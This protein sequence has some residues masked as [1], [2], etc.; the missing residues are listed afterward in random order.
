M[1]KETEERGVWGKHHAT[2]YRVEERCLNYGGPVVHGKIVN[3][4]QIALRN[5]LW[6]G[7]QRE[8][9]MIVFAHKIKCSYI[10]ENALKGCE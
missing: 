2:C 10:V 1:D 8:N 4:I 3:F 5:E 6:Q 7:L 9:S